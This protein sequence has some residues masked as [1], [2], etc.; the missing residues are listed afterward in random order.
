MTAALAWVATIAWAATMGAG[1]G[2]MGMSLAPFLLVWVLMM[3]AMMFPSVAPMALVW[4]RWVAARPRTQERVAGIVFF[5]AGYLCAW[6]SFGAAVYV[7]LVGAGKLAHDAPDAARWTGAAIFAV[8]ALYQ[9]TPLKSACLRHCRS[10][11]GS[12]FHYASYRALDATSESGS[13]TGST[14]SVAA[15]V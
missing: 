13:T 6:A 4:V 11:V 1:P 12:L 2:T 8:A 15:G 10:P 7:V 3:A 14:A 9:L 5:L